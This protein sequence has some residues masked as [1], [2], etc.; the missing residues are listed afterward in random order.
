MRI[1]HFYLVAI[2]LL[3][4]IVGIL[5]QVYFWNYVPDGGPGGDWM[6]SPAI[7][8]PPLLALICLWLHADA[9]HRH[10]MLPAWLLIGAPIVFP[11]G[12]PF[13]YFR[14]SELPIA[15]S[16]LGLFLL[17]ACSCLA[18]LWIGSKLA[19]NYYAVWTNG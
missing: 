12:I 18:A 1:T 7:Y 19:F 4:L 10:A 9:K 2:L 11:I 15:F 6:T 16:R 3:H 13:Y 5:G 8:W 17:F 14:S